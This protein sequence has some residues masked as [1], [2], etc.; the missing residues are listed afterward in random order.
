[1]ISW[2]YPTK[3]LSSVPPELYKPVYKNLQTA[4]P[5][6]PA[7]DSSEAAVSISTVIKLLD[8][9]NQIALTEKSDPPKMT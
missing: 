5:L 8:R 6:K 1:M 4:T 2:I 7:G 9:H 3:Q